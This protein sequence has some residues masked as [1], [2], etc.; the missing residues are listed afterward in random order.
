MF[1]WTGRTYN[2]SS[3][4]ALLAASSGLHGIKGKAARWK[5]CAA[6]CVRVCGWAYFTA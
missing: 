4:N 6:T 1:Y 2:A 3:G 5:V